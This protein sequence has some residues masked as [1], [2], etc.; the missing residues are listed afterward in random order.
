[1]QNRDNWE[2]VMY[3][4]DEALTMFVMFITIIFSSAITSML[5]TGDVA[6]PVSLTI[7]WTKTIATLLI[8]VVTYGLMTDNYKYHPG[9]TKPNLYKRLYNGILHGMAWKSMI[10]ISDS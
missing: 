8:T 10:G 6:N 5:K 9:K 7:N 4:V 3:Y 1:M 2:K